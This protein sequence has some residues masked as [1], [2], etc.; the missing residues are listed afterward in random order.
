LIETSFQLLAQ[1]KQNH[2]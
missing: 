2:N 1:G